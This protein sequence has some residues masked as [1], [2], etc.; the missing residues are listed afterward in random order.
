MLAA[1]LLLAAQAPAQA[2]DKVGFAKVG[3]VIDPFASF[4]VD[5]R[6][7]A[8]GLATTVNPRGPGA[9]WWNPAPLPGGEEVAV[10]Y[11]IWEY[12]QDWLQVRPLALRA[13]HRNLTAGA[14]WHRSW[15]EPDP[16]RTGHEPDGTGEYESHD[17]LFQLGLA[18]DLVPW[19]HGSG[20]DWVWTVGANLRHF[21]SEFESAL[22][23]V[24]EDRAWD[25]DLGTSVSWGLEEETVSAR[26]HATA[27][28]RNLFRADVA[29]GDVVVGLAR[30]YHFG[31]GLEAGLGPRWRGH[32][33][34]AATVAC[35]L[36]RDLDH[37]LYADWDSEHV[38]FELTAG[39]ILSLRA[40]VRTG[41]TFSDSDR[42]WS[43]GAGLQHEWAGL[44]AAVDYATFEASHSAIGWDE[45][46]DHWTFTL[47]Y[48]WAP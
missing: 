21:R 33:L 22:G 6:G 19:L 20:S 17:D 28:A 7:E 38:G 3:P 4:A 25:A 37:L 8:M 2:P 43:W 39:G 26:L 5:A 9:F 10:S 23:T 40:G 36:R 47:G 29:A 45:R 14:V 18:A 12:P 42:G 27:M 48:G 1:A 11:T 35:A 30:Y 34:V 31:V 13:S 44:R 15:T 41:L 32:R 46:L 24:W 16:V